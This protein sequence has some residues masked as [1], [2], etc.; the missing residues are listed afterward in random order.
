MASAPDAAPSVEAWL[1][2]PRHRALGIELLR[3][4]VGLVWALNLIYIL[5]PA[6]SWF[7][8]FG[9][10]AQSYGPTT[11]GGPGLANFVAAHA[12]VF[13]WLVAT[14]TAYLA[15]AFLLGA[16]T[17]I[18]CMVGGVFSAVLLATQV[19]S[20]FSFPGGTDV[21]EHPL[22][23]VIYAALVIGGAGRALSVDRRLAEALAHR[24]ARRVAQGL[25]VP[26]RAW[27]AP[28]DYRFF[29]AY[30]AAG[31]LIAFSVTVG[32]MVTI[33][34]PGP[35][36]AGSPTVYYENLSVVINPVNGWPQYTPANFT[37]P[38]GLVT[39][40]INDHD[41]PM[42]WSQCPCVVSGT[43]NGFES[44]NG[45]LFHV[46]PS[47][48]IAHTFTVPNLGIEIYSPGQA[49]VEF[50]VDLVNPG[51]FTWF[52]IAPCGTGSNP[53]T[54]PPM[55]TFGYMSGTMSVS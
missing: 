31:I 16:T 38:A 40:R 42:A 37:V 19:G 52:C 1:V 34:S 9:A 36:G 20:T 4:G 43:T 47:T 50:T 3:I 23:L 51:N 33:P 41:S 18:A 22:F 27:T 44:L 7:A 25:P 8:D 28:L 29:L 13:S 17:R 54:T 11:V 55:G 14:V 5:A 48:N 49:V 10:T 45:T 21:G 35:A 46:V 53:Y 32:L 26:A 2:S 30:F 15:V 39:F 6:N 12:T 24:Q